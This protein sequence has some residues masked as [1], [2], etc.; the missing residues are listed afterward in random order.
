MYI[1]LS[2]CLSVCMYKH[3]EDDINIYEFGNSI[4]QFTVLPSSCIYAISVL[5][6]HGPFKKKRCIVWGKEL[7]LPHSE[8]QLRGMM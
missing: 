2:V 8:H 5:V 4:Y 3:N 7:L 1:Y 6:I